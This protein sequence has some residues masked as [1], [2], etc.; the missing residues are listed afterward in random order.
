MG[1]FLTKPPE[2]TP[3]DKVM[4]ALVIPVALEKNLALG[5]GSTEGGFPLAKALQFDQNEV[6]NLYSI[7]AGELKFHFQEHG[8]AY[9][10][11]VASD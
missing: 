8:V 5:N 7:S 3:E 6:P 1:G 10:E 2:P 11:T 9:S 4:A